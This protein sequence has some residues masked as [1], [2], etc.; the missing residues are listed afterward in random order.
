MG[1]VEQVSVSFFQFQGFFL[2]KVRLSGKKQLEQ[3]Q[4]L[5]K[6]IIFDQ[7]KPVVPQNQTF[8]L[9]KLKPGKKRQR[10]VASS[11]SCQEGRGVRVLSRRGRD[12]FL[13]VP[14]LKKWWSQ[15]P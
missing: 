2:K 4:K 3:N 15:C 6:N 9:K 11:V 12:R 1:R 5:E 13:S 7:K 8:Y 14:S 10:G